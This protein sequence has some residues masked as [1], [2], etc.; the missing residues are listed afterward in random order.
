MMILADFKI[1]NYLKMKRFVGRIIL[2]LLVCISFY[3]NAQQKIPVSRNP[4]NSANQEG[5][6]E[7]TKSQNDS[8]L[9]VG[10]PKNVRVYSVNSKYINFPSKT[11]IDTALHNI[12]FYNPAKQAMSFSQD[13]GNIGTAST[14]IDLS[15]NSKG[16]INFGGNAFD[17]FLKE[18]TKAEII[19]T[20][21]PFTQLTYVMGSKK[22]NVLRVQHAQR[23]LEEQINAGI[24]FKLIN[25][26]GYYARQKSDIKNLNS[27]FAYR[28]KDKRY[29][30]LA[31]Y[32]HNK[33]V[34]QENGGIVHDSL[35][36]QNIQP[37]RQIIDVN[38]Q[39]AENYVK[40]S[41]IS[42]HQNF[43]IAKAE[44]DF[45]AIP[46]T[47]VLNLD[48]YSV[49]HYKKPYF[50]PITP[51]GR[52]THAFNYS[53]E[54]YQ[55]SDQSGTSGFYSTLPDF[56]VDQSTT[57]D[58]ITLR[59]IENVFSYNNSDY[60]DKIEKLQ[61]LTYSV[62]LGIISSR[63]SQDTIVKTLTELSTPARLQLVIKD[64]V[65]LKAEG[66]YAYRDDKTSSYKLNGNLKLQIKKNEIQFSFASISAQAPLIYQNFYSNYFQWDNDFVNQKFQ[67]AHAQF[68]REL[69]KITLNTGIVHDYLYFDE[70]VKP[71]QY[72]A[73]LSFI[74]AAIYKGLRFGDFGID[75][76]VLYQ[77]VSD[78][79]IVRIPKIL[80][81]T[82]LFYSN[83]IFNGAL[84]LE[85]GF[86]IRYFTK[87]YANSYMPALRNFYLQ[88]EVE[89]G[90]YPYV[91]FYVNAK[92]KRARLFF[93][94]EQ[95]N[96][97]YMPEN[98]FITPH[99]PN[100]DAGFKFGVI[101]QLF[102]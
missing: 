102:N 64:W 4:I 101:W 84:D 25:S 76:N 23:F 95:L 44:P 78:T 52:L 61:F 60:K 94:Y 8:L 68:S 17:L 73:P 54:L 71:Q 3:A 29:S 27:N 100:A 35:Y 1:K 59:K 55:Y 66:F 77:N 28:T 70:N 58:S 51:L 20:P 34:V 97:A 69:T 99:Y 90:N 14:P 7:E 36:E 89:L 31:I 2:L 57:F 92:I 16:G 11:I 72:K 6:N 30:V 37:N 86:N 39:T 40:L 88:S 96:A 74:K 22:E 13:L 41:G 32:Y 67:L 85:L 49:Y 26:I 42:I 93:K 45:S 24:D 56:P 9:N 47:N 46:D 75:I 33:V 43:Y 10:N 5:L 15:F 38:M 18:F 62:G 50:D 65:F 53:K 87:Y 79:S 80:A 83:T 81:N 12:D 21:T 63:Y 19:E 91:D 48:S 82:K 98:Y